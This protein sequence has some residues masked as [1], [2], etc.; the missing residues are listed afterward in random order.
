MTASRQRVAG[1]VLRV[2]ALLLLGRFL[3][4]TVSAQVTQPVLN[5]TNGHYYEAVSAAQRG[6]SDM[7]AAAADRRFRG[8]QGH[9]VTF[10]TGQEHQFVVSQ[11]PNAVSGGW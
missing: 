1:A 3:A 2:A 9:L 10:T 7:K 5:P 8:M 11:L 4:R 6:W